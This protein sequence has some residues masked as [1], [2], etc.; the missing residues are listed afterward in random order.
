MAFIKKY[1]RFFILYLFKKLILRK[2]IT[3]PLKLASRQSLRFILSFRMNSSFIILGPGPLMV[4]MIL[5]KD[6]K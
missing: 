4:I 6:T 2:K 3:K 5:V 1:V